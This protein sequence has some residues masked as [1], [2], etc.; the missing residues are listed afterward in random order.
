M[1]SKMPKKPEHLSDGSMTLFSFSDKGYFLWKRGT[2]VTGYW[3][4]RKSK[5]DFRR[6][7]E[8]KTKGQYA[9][10]P[11]SLNEFHGYLF[12]LDGTVY[13]GDTLL[14]GVLSTLNRLREQN[15]SLLFVSNTTIRTVEEVRM[16][17]EQLGVVCSESE[18]MTA[19]CA[20]GMYFQ[21]Y[22]PGA[23][24]LMIGEQAMKRELER[25]DVETTEDASGATH[26]L[27]GMDRQFTYDRL[28]QGMK[29]LRN[30]ALLIAAN[31][32]PFCPLDD[33]A[34]P[35]TWSLVRAL[36][37][38]SLRQTFTVIG[39]PSAYYAEKVFQKLDIAPEEC[40]MVGDRIETDIRFG[41]DHGM[42]S[43]LVLTGADS[44]KDIVLTGIEPDYVL[45]SLR[46]ILADW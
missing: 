27:V 35:D 45:A 7:E 25:F 6:R 42:Y 21:E 29:A 1:F 2:K 28:T 22:E 10:R 19:S 23:R 20:A 16:R 36:E 9:K 39:K 33:G 11:K 13:S 40:L 37:T 26:V 46:D 30:G 14:P 5:H 8:A 24:V 18:I 31:P 38:A 15:K 34:I 12:D 44:R 3:A 43:T 17:L 41:N 4:Y 32:D